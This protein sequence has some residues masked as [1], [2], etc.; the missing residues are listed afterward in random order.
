MA[1]S[2]DLGKN[3]ETVV[4]V[5]VRRGRYNSRSEVLRA[6]VR[7]LHERE[8]RIAELEAA[9]AEGVSDADAGRVE[10][11]RT[12]IDRVK[13]EFLRR[14]SPVKRRRAGSSSRSSR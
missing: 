13:R 11:V 9:I 2:V 3:L 7:L 4:E 12:A 6:G 8:I 10:D 1:S 14:K 5:L